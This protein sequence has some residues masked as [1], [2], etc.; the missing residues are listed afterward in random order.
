M[1]FL[2]LSATAFFLIGA[3]LL[4]STNATCESDEECHN[5]GTCVDLGGDGHGHAGILPG[6]CVCSEGF[7]GNYCTQHCPLKCQ[8]GG[9]CDYESNEHAFVTGATDFICVCPDD[10]DGV[11]CDE[12]IGEAKR[13][14]KRAIKEGGVIAGIVVAV[15]FVIGVATCIGVK[16]CKR[17]KQWKDP[18]ETSQDP[19]SGPDTEKNTDNIE[20]AENDAPEDLP[21][22]S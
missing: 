5:G 7:L 6:R 9:H 22:L 15:L 18:E 2:R 11:V 17:G 8:N 10:Y 16:C 20:S 14:D 4:P 1:I 21:E 3:L 13:T 12:Y 19:E